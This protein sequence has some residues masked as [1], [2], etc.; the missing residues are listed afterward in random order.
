VRFAVLGSGS[1]GNAI[2][3][4][5]G[6]VRVL[7][8]CG[9]GP[10][11]I[12]RRLEHLEVDVRNLDALLIT[13]GHGDHV[14]GARQLAGALHIPT[15]ATE[16][17]KRFCHGFGGLRNATLFSPGERFAV[18]GLSI[19]PVA[20]PHDAPGSVCFVLDDGEERLGVCTDLGA[21]TAPI[22][23]ALSTCHA[24]VL[25]HN[26]DLDMLQRG[27]YSAALK[28]RI[29][30][31]RG[32]LSNDDG[33]RLLGMSSRGSLTRVLL[34]H[35]SEV[36]NT[37]A[38]ALAA[39]RP[40]VDPDVEVAIAPQ[41]HPTGWLRARRARVAPSAH[42]STSAGAG[43]VTPSARAD[44]HAALER[45]LALFATTPKMTSTRSR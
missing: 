13:H 14:K 16:Q 10:R 11:E 38:L 12:K 4:E 44:R 3:V 15:Y 1:K 39:A 32:H 17:T 36:N 27:P 37:P 9:Y 31:T 29:A 19:L 26:H 6:G 2:V 40:V 28:R 42:G 35:L 21:P 5:G 7:V 23:A 30:S 8:D 45:Q 18:G 25:E 41:H 22:A 33:A 34:A 24:L 20:T 43:A